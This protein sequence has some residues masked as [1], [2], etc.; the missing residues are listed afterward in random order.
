MELLALSEGRCVAGGQQQAQ[1]A[2]PSTTHDQRKKSLLALMG[3]QPHH[4]MPKANRACRG[5]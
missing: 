5:S 3:E 1:D 2:R 4:T